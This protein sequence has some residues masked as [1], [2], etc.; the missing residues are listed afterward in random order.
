[1]R[2]RLQDHPG[3]D[4]RFIEDAPTAAADGYFVASFDNRAGWYERTIFFR[5]DKMIDGRPECA[6]RKA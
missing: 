3:S 6:V 5:V 2:G 1:M 4:T